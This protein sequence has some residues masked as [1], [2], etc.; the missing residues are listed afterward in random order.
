MDLNTTTNA[1]AG[2]TVPYPV[3]CSAQG[4]CGWL[5][6][7]PSRLDLGH[8]KF[9]GGGG[10]DLNLTEVIDVN[11]TLDIWR[12]VLSSSWTHATSGTQIQAET[13]RVAFAF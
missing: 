3:N 10:V 13:V 2:R 7:N 1:G 6:Q 9:V 5:A 12:G 4:P 8:L 11:Q